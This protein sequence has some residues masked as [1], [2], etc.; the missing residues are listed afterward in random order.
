MSLLRLYRLRCDIDGCSCTLDVERPSLEAARSAGHRVG[1]S[2]PVIDGAKRDACPAC[3]AKRR[4]ERHALAQMLAASKPAQVMRGVRARRMAAKCCIYCPD[5]PPLPGRLYGAKCKQG[6]ADR[7][8]KTEERAER[9][10]IAE[11][12]NREPRL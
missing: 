1:W 5:E 2:R 8:Q 9:A 10:L 7:R 6:F 11:L 3:T 4:R 12:R